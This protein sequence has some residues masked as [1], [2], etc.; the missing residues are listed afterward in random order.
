MPCSQ[1]RSLDL[2]WGTGSQEGFRQNH[3]IRRAFLKDL[4][5]CTS[6]LFRW[7]LSLLLTPSST[8]AVIIHF[9]AP[10]V[11]NSFMRLFYF[12]CTIISPGRG[13]TF[14]VRPYLSFPPQ[15]LEVGWLVC[16]ELCPWKRS[17]NQISLKASRRNPTLPTPW[18]WTSSLQNWERTLSCCFK[19][20]DLL[21]LVTAAIGNW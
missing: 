5:G 3:L 18:F 8:H 6:F 11:T 12:S 4:S 14:Y 17:W 16:V 19:P 1:V 20:P 2:S 7:K 10:L 15:Y 9:S 13:C 21:S